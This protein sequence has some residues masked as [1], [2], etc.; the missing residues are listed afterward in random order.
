LHQNEFYIILDNCI[1]FIGFP[2]EL[3]TIFNFKA[4][5]RYFVPNDWIKVIKP[6]FPTKETDS[7]PITPESV[8]FS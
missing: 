7:Y 8:F 2:Q 3:G 1:G 5:I 4:G 6:D